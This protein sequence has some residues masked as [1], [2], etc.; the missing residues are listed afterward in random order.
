[1]YLRMVSTEIRTAHVRSMMGMTAGNFRYRF[2]LQRL[3]GHYIDTLIVPHQHVFRSFDPIGLG[4]SNGPS[5]RH[6]DSR[7]CVSELSAE[8]QS[9]KAV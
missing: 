4:V 2:T 3:I 1:M 5:W 8:S 6:Q 7:L 9:G